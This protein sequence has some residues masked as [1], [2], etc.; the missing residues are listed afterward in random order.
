MFPELFL[1]LLIC[2]ALDSVLP[3]VNHAEPGFFLNTRFIRCNSHTIKFTLVY[4][5][6]QWVLEYSVTQ[7]SPS[8]NSSTFSSPPTETH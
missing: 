8:S 6:I 7:L 4:Y 1:F 2:V 3:N 5:A